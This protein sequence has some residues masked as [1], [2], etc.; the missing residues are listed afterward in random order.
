MKVVTILNNG[1]FISDHGSG[2]T[3][4]GAGD[5]QSPGAKRQDPGCQGCW[6]AQ[7]ASD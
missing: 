6:Q 4:A 3:P 2:T 5:R 1:R 7:K